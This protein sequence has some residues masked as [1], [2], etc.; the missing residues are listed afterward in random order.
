MGFSSSLYAILTHVINRDFIKKE[1]RFS[2]TTEWLRVM[3]MQLKD[4]KKKK[5]KK[6]PWGKQCLQEPPARLWQHS[7]TSGREAMSHT[8]CAG[9]AQALT[10]AYCGAHL[11]SADQIHP[12]PPQ[13]NTAMLPTQPDSPWRQSSCFVWHRAKLMSFPRPHSFMPGAPDLTRLPS[14]LS[15]TL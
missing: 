5:K 8:K 2:T 1:Y 6:P 12:P 15:I 14:R 11:S 10:T 9:G 4:I 7:V 13:A 3:E